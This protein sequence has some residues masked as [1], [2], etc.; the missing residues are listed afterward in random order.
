MSRKRAKPAFSS[1]PVA[2]GRPR[3]RDRSQQTERLRRILLGVVTALIVIRPFVLGE[4]PGLLNQMSGAATLILSMAWLLAAL[5]T[6]IW[7]VWAAAP[8]VRIHAVE[9]GLAF[10]AGLAFLTAQTTA[11]YQLPARLIAWEF[12]ILL[13]VFGVVRRVASSPV[14]RGYLLAALLATGVSLSA[15]AIY[16]YAVEFPRMRATFAS[17]EALSQQVARLNLSLAADDPRL[18]NWM[19]RLQQNNVFATYAHPNSFAG[20]LAL[21]MPGTLCWAFLCW[22]RDRRWSWSVGGGLAAA[23]LVLIALG[24]THSRGAIL[25]SLLAAGLLIP[26]VRPPAM[27]KRPR[28]L[29]GLGAVALLAVVVAA[30]TPIGTSGLAKARAS[31][32]LRGDYWVATLAMIREHAF[33]GVGWGGFGRL[34]P[35]YMLPTAF[36]KIQDP[37]NFLLETWAC[38]GLLSALVLLGTLAAFYIGWVRQV[39]LT[40]ADEEAAPAQPRAEFYWGGVVGLTLAFVLRAGDVGSGEIFTEGALSV[41]RAIVW[42]LAFAVFTSLPVIGRSLLLAMGVGITALLC[43][44]LISGG[45]SQPSVAQPL[46]TMAALALPVSAAARSDRRLAWAGLGGAAVLVLIFG[47][48]VYEPMWQVDALVGDARR[49]YGV[50]EAPGWRNHVLE[51]WKSA[52]ASKNPRS[53]DQAYRESNQYLKQHILQPLEH[54]MELSPKDAKLPAELAIWYREQWELDPENDDLARKAIEMARKVQALDPESREGF[55]LEFSLQQER[56]E[57]FPQ[58]AAEY[59]RMALHALQEAADRDPT[60]AGLHYELAQLLFT[61]VDDAAGKKEAARALELNA[62]SHTPGRTLT[63]RQVET[64]RQR[65]GAPPPQ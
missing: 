55:S 4:D 63:D 65:L 57:R 14:E 10:F 37:H 38:G 30:L 28:F 26:F 43:N 15:Y 39:R 32:G 23:L 52:V 17:P 24:L 9:W 22:R 5:A 31:L 46:W 34:Y 64:L 44:L 1:Q 42:F 40:L 12:L 13:L 6:A 49:Y 27:V 35:R 48:F 59:R 29:V 45:I 62:V 16:Q 61:L 19:E 2:A 33:W 47:L 25:G 18:S 51:R 56:A 60:E 8:A 50:G 7:R 53:I 20:F 3:P 41:A 54:A 11:R 36:E 58:K 21:V